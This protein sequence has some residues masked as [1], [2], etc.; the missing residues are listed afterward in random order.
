MDEFSLLLFS[1]E[2]SCH[3]LRLQVHRN[4]A[5]DQPQRGRAPRGYAR[6]DPAEAPGCRGRPQQVQSRPQSHGPTREGLEDAKQQDQELR[7]PT[8]SLNQVLSKE[9]REKKGSKEIAKQ[10]TFFFPLKKEGQ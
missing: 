4:L 7:E 1:R 5:R 10:N 3:S 6:P 8:R 9:G 2:V